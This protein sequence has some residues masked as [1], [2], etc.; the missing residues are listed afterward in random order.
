MF[1]VVLEEYNRQIPKVIEDYIC[2]LNII[3]RVINITELAE[4]F[5]NFPEERFVMTQMILETTFFTTQLNSPLLMSDRI[6]F[7]NVEMLTEEKRFNRML[8][9]LKYTN[10]CIADYSIENIYFLKNT[11][12]DNVFSNK[13]IYFPYQFNLKENLLLTNNE[14]L[15]EYDIGIINAYVEKSDTVDSSLTYRRNRIWNDLQKEKNL[16]I[17]NIMGWNED[18]DKLIKK[19]KIIMNVHHFECFNIHE[20]IRCDRLVFAKKIVISD[21]SIYQEETDTY[22]YIIYSDYEKLIEKAKSVLENFDIFNTTM[23]TT[24]LE[25]LIES[26]KKILQN[27]V[28]FVTS[29]DSS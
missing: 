27:N 22:D 13:I 5:N 3:T 29:N 2:S 26:R 14:D 28:N 21:K 24:S 15:Y 4:Y 11:L 20:C 19:C 7:L 1:L 23:K 10:F 18:R 9:I 16:K 6:I 8:D 12:K 25:S 17:I